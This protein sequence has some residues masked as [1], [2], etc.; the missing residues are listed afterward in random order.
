MVLPTL[1]VVLEVTVTL[2]LLEGRE[3]TIVV[4]V[5]LV[6]LA[7]ERTEFGANVTDQQE[8]ATLLGI[9]GHLQWGK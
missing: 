1:P 2:I 7:Q 8:S 5:L 6:L 4:V 9:C 3:V